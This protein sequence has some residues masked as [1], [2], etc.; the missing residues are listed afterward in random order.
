ME[1]LGKIGFSQSYTY[2]TWRNTKWDIEAYMAELTKTASKYFFRPNF[3]PNTPDIL[4]PEL[5][6]G[7]ENAHIIRLVLAAT[8]SSNYGVY[9]PVYE[10]GIDEPV[11]GKEEYKDNEKYEIKHWDWDKYT[12]IKEIMTRINKIRK[13]NPALQSTNNIAFAETTNQHIVCYVKSDPKTNNVLI[14]AVNLDPHN[15]QAAS[16]KMPHTFATKHNP[17]FKVLDLLNGDR[18]Q[19]T[20]EWNYVSLNPFDLPAHVFLVEP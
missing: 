3:W 2:F 10:F 12:R 16:V 6:A 9:G 15:T 14:I 19:W 8:L 20:N 17:S 18:W 13:E 4:H 1:W 11:A 7:K 5:T